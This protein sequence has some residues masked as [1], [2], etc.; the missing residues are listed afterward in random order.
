MTE[1]GAPNLLRDT[2]VYLSGPM[3][4]VASRV[5][6]KQFGWRNR[7]AE[8]LRA[9]GVTVFD[10][11]FKPEIRGIA[12]YGREDETTAK[13]RDKWNFD[14][15][16]AGTKDRAACAQHF[17]P[18]QHLDLRMVDVSDFV[19][20]YVPTNVYSVGT[21][22]EIIQ[23]RAEHKPVL[24]VSPPVSFPSLAKLEEHLKSDRDG[25]KLL[26]A[27]KGEVPIK[28]NPTGSPSLWC[29]PLVDSEQFFDGFGF[30]DYRDQFGWKPVALDDHEELHKPE[31][32]L[33][34]YIEALNNKLP[35]KWDWRKNTFVANDDWLLWQLDGGTDTG[36]QVT[37]LSGR[38][39]GGTGK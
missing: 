1:S 18:A 20:A 27:L 21:P 33:L 14:P 22:H 30:A 5:E 34:P 4:F 16:E 39:S 12:E 8:F 17:W 38:P 10:P 26:D 36:G 24:L 7:V 11:W 28:E 9:L 32:P 31:K 25:L 23:C 29:M 6:E 15:S 35:A 37:G 13:V 3:D 2:R 19:V